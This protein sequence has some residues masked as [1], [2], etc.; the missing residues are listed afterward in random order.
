MLRKF[1]IAGSRSQTV[2][3]FSSRKIINMF[4]HVMTKPSKKLSKDRDARRC[5]FD[6]R[7][8]IKNNPLNCA[9]NEI[10]ALTQKI[11]HSLIILITM[12]LDQIVIHPWLYAL[13]LSFNSYPLLYRFNWNAPTANCLS[14]TWSPVR[15]S[16]TVSH[17]RWCTLATH[18]WSK[19]PTKS[20]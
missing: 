16:P 4:E 6:C 19:K 1:T 7:L 2:Q 3:L 18:F 14:S 10:C 17:T 20:C 15:S 8:N 11:L 12:K 13:M 9:P 5:L